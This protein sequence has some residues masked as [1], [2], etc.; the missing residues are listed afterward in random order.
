MKLLF[1]RKQVLHYKSNA[2]VYL[3]HG[4]VK[5]R[6]ACTHIDLSLIFKLLGI[7]EYIIDT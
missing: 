7:N 2:K 5:T 3:K 4:Q 6:I 1:N